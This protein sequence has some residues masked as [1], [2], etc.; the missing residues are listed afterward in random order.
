MIVIDASVANKLVLPNEPDYALA[1]S[2]LEKH[3]L[4]TE[5]I[6]VLDFLFYEVANTLATKSSISSI[7]MVNSLTKIYAANLKIYCP[8]EVEVKEAAKLA[9]QYKTSVYDMI[10][11]VI[12][13]NH[14]IILITADEKFMKQTGFKWVKLLKDF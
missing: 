9:K 7:R 12:A 13:K 3:I 14:K 10:Y 4:Q 2:I 1:K 5:E 6:L 8:A 11:A